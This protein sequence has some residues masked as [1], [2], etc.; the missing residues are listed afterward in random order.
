MLSLYTDIDECTPVSL[1]RYTEQQDEPTRKVELSKSDAVFT[2]HELSRSG[3][4]E[5]AGVWLLVA[6]AL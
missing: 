5:A 6:D 3:Q 1:V 4:Y 2:S